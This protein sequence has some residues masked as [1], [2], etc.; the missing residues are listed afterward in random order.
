MYT[1]YTFLASAGTDISIAANHPGMSGTVPDL[2][3]LSRIKGLLSQKY[4]HVMI[5][6]LTLNFPANFCRSAKKLPDL[7]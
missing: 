4:E 7:H 2:L 5:T 1:F 6:V 3:A